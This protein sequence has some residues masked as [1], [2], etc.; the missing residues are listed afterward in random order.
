MAGQDNFLPGSG[1]API[2]KNHTPPFQRFP[3]K[4]PGIPRRIRQRG[5][6]RETPRSQRNCAG[7]V[8]P[9]PPRSRI[10]H[11][12]VA[13]ALRPRPHRHFPVDAPVDVRL[14]PEKGRGIP[15]FLS[16]IEDQPHPIVPDVQPERTGSVCVA[17]IPPDPMVTHRIPRKNRV[18][19]PQRP[20]HTLQAFPHRVLRQFLQIRLRKRRIPAPFHY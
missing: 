18:I 6:H 16:G 11:D 12:S 19:H 20:H 15:F 8:D 10:H 9:W 3:Q 7:R 4:L 2:G 17:Q 1:R 5:T 13:A 14:T